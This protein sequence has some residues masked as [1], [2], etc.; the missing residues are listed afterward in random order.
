MKVLGVP[1][2][3]WRR[4][5]MLNLAFLVILASVAIGLPRANAQNVNISTARNCDANAVI[6]CGASS[7]NQLI[8]K[9]NN[10]DGHNSAASIQNIFAAF[11]ISAADINSMNNAGA[12]VQA[13]T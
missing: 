3:I 13:G 11:G 2:I 6:F 9:V 4:L 12:N 10:G 1:A 8:N 5:C 7:V